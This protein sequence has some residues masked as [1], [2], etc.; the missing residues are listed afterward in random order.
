LAS[1]ALRRAAAV[2]T[3]NARAVD[4]DLIVV[5]RGDRQLAWRIPAYVPCGSSK[6]PPARIATEAR[7]RTARRW[8][9]R[10]DRT[11]SPWAMDVKTWLTQKS[12]AAGAVS[13]DTARP[14]PAVTLPARPYPGP[15]RLGRTMADLLRPRA[16]I[17]DV[18]G[19]A[20]RQ[21]LLV[22]PAT[23]LRQDSLTGPVLPRLGR[24]RRA[25]AGAD[26]AGDD[27]G[28]RAARPPGQALVDRLG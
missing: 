12:V 28:R 6:S 5:G 27:A 25:A 2:G 10:I 23:R 13:P 24:T 4:E 22:V 15:R 16:M 19:H 3:N 18:V 1:W 7:R 26:H 14:T 20:G 8:V 17:D 11:R 21:R 9:D